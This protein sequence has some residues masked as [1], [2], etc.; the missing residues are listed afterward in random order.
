[1]CLF[2]QGWITISPSRWQI[3]K[4]RGKKGMR[5]SNPI[6]SLVFLS[7]NMMKFRWEGYFNTSSE[8]GFLFHKQ[9]SFPTPFLTEGKYVLAESISESGNCMKLC[10]LVLITISEPLFK[11]PRGREMESGGM[12]E[13]NSTQHDLCSLARTMLILSVQHQQCLVYVRKMLE[14]GCSRFHWLF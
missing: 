3:K 6:I 10:I 8:N 13:T 4:L 11:Y 1:M 7:S 12:E 9:F 5:L 14:A 2:V